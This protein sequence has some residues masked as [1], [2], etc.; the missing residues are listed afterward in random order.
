MCGGQMQGRT[1]EVKRSSKRRGKAALPRESM[2]SLWLKAGRCGEAA[3]G[4]GPF[5]AGGGIGWKNGT[6]GS[7]T[8]IVSCLK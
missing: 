8:A 6:K 2:K 3:V 4:K 5:P 1:G 7:S